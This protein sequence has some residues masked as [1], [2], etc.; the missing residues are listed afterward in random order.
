MQVSEESGAVI[1]MVDQNGCNEIWSTIES[2]VG[3][4]RNAVVLDFSEVDYLNSI[5]IAAIIT[6]RNK[7]MQNGGRMALTGLKDQIASIFRVL[8][9]ERMFDLTQTRDEAIADVTESG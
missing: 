2:Q 3:D 6:L 1:V 4:G 7:V 9:L 8:K 5:N